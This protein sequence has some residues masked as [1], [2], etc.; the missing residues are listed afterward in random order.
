MS[1]IY[2]LSA[3]NKTAPWF[4]L[5]DPPSS[6]ETFKL[7][8]RNSQITSFESPTG[9]LFSGR[10]LFALTCCRWRCRKMEGSISS[11]VCCLFFKLLPVWSW[12][13]SHHT[14]PTPSPPPQLLALYPLQ[15][16]IFDIVSKIRF[17]QPYF[18]RRS[19]ALSLFGKRKV[20]YVNDE[21]ALERYFTHKMFLRL[22]FFVY[23]SWFSHY[24]VL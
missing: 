21:E 22:F 5:I 16:Q 12:T 23:S 14:A 18:Q 10:F 2:Q 4:L 7:S 19:K 20:N 6:H 13:R 24:T 8:N 11:L 15:V 9:R 1:K 17:T 3:I